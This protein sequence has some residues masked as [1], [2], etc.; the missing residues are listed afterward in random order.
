MFFDS[1]SHP[2]L[3]GQWV[4]NKPGETFA[5][6][7]EAYKIAGA[8]G[9]CAVG[10]SGIGGYDHKAYFRECSV[11]DN[12]LPVASLTKKECITE[13]IEQIAEIGY[14]ALKIHPRLMSIHPTHGVLSEAFAAAGRMNM[15]VFL[16]TYVYDKPERMISSDPYWHLV[17]AVGENPETRIVLL[18]GGAVRLLEYAEL[19]RFTDKVLLDLSFTFQKYA[20]SSVA[21][22]IRYLLQSFDRKI[23]FGVDSPE[24]CLPGSLSTLERVTE[25]LSA[26]KKQNVMFGNLMSL[27]D[28]KIPSI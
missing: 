12:L 26:E 4:S 19:C 11:F 8:I 15:T 23:C 17:K 7:S 28:L 3:N 18:H 24:Y 13:E 25:G 6:V 22:D 14:R 20:S 21:Q 2:T 9:G 1:L 16:C 27:L 5:Q 10:L